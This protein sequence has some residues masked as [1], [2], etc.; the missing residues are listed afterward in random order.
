MGLSVSDFS[1]M[2]PTEFNAIY[3]EWQSRQEDNERGRW[4]RCRWIC[5]YALKPYAKNGLKPED[6]LRFGWDG[7][8][9][10]GGSKTKMTK[11]E[12]EADKKEFE[13]LMEL[14]KDE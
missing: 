1:R 11:E 13:K 2:T 5:Y 10:T 6:V 7:G 12:L 8:M 14:W 4:E 9:N 3:K